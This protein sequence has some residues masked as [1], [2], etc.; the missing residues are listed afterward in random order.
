MNKHLILRKCMKT[1]LKSLQKALAI[2]ARGLYLF[3]SVTT[4]INLHLSYQEIAL[5]M[6]E[7]TSPLHFTCLLRWPG[8]DY[9][10]ISIVTNVKLFYVFCESIRA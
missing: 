4:K 1:L 2:M 8:C 10:K 5:S 7:V 3:V 9:N 6:L